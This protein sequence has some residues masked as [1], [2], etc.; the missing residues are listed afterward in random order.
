M[1]ITLPQSSQKKPIS[2]C[3]LFVPQ[4]P[5][6]LKNSP[7]LWGAES[8][9][10]SLTVQF[11]YCPSQ[12]KINFRKKNMATNVFKNFRTEVCKTYNAVIAGSNASTTNF[13]DIS[14]IMSMS[15]LTAIPSQSMLSTLAKSSICVIITT[16]KN[17]ENRGSFSTALHEQLHAN[18][19]LEIENQ[20]R[21][22][23]LPIIRLFQ[24]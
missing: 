18:N 21:F 16:H 19:M 12:K 10:K 23:Q 7:Q 9:A 20:T 24:K 11:L 4:K 13:Q 1:I 5:T 8:T 6:T 2:S 17:T 3:A 22:L 15:S 14:K